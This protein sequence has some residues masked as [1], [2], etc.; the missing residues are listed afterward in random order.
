MLSLGWSLGSLG[1]G[2]IIHAWGRRRASLA[3]ALLLLSG[4]GPTLFFGPQTSMAWCLVVF[5]LAGLGM[6]FVTMATLMIVQDCLDDADL[7]MATASNQLARTLGG[8][9]GI[10][11]GGGLLMA[12]LGTAVA[13]MAGEPAAALRQ[14]LNQLFLP[15]TQMHLSPEWVTLFQRALGDGLQIVFGIALA[16]ALVCLW[17]CWRL[18]RDQ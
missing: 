17:A 5:F 15:E 9:I 7:G 6:G 18:P 11:I 4:C 8:T 14:E 3:G 10:G 13:G 2:Q 16:S 12:R 1:L